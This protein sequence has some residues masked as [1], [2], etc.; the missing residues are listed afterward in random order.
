MK[1]KILAT[2]VLCLFTLFSAKAQ[3]ENFVVLI[4]N[5]EHQVKNVELFNKKSFKTLPK[6][7]PKNIFSIG[8]VKGE[9]KESRGIIILQKGS[10]IHLAS[11]KWYIP[12]VDT[13]LPGDGFLP[14]DAFKPGDQFSVG[15]NKVELQRSKKGSVILKVI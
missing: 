11:A 13:F 1:T 4:G 5:K 2:V 9:F 15:E 8:L 7:Y 10:Y 14:G 3:E 6:K 12:E